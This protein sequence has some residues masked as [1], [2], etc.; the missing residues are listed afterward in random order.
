LSANGI[1]FVGMDA[2]KKAINVAMLLPGQNEPVEW[3]LANEPAAIRRLAKKLQREAPGEVRCCYEAGPCGY[4]LQRQLEA[5]AG[6]VCEVVAPS[7]IPVKPGERIKTDRRDARKLARL[8]RSED[9]TA[10]HAPTSADEA[11]RDLCRCR[12]DARKDLLRAR[13]RLDTF[14]LRRAC[15][16]TL[17][18]RRWGQPYRAWLNSLKF[19]H[20]PDQVTFDD[21]L[22]TIAQAEERLGRLDQQLGLVAEQDPYREPVGWLRC[23]R[24]ID[25]MT[26]VT[27]VAELHDF[28]RFQTARALMAYLGLVPSEHSSGERQRRGA[29]TKAG[30]IHVRRLLIEAAW[31]YRHRP[32]VGVGI[33][34]RRRG[35]PDPIIA[36]A[37]RAQDRLFHRFH[38]LTARG[39]LPNKAVVAVA[40][41]LV[42]FVWA[43]LYPA[44]QQQPPRS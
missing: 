4:V 1:T 5:A 25:T 21:Y 26:A 24:G 7:L 8:L 12:E 2:H 42:G 18:R 37:D 29:I 33:R 19:E 6:V 40:R 14:L 23:F 9:L 35:Q 28:R 10:V 38:T 11:V 17:T 15:L 20:T 39:K 3:Q 22:R 13:H 30:N 43:A 41:E 36:I 31:H 44:T 32:H 27:V 16:Y 34:Q